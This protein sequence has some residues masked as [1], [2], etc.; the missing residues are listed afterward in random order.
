MKKIFCILSLCLLFSVACETENGV[1]TPTVSDSSITC[2]NTTIDGHDA[3]I[4]QPVD[5]RTKAPVVI[6]LTDDL[7]LATRNTQTPEVNVNFKVAEHCLIGGYKICVIKAQINDNLSFL[8]TAKGLFAGAS[9]FYLL[10]YRNGL[11]YTAAMQMPET[12]NAYG[13]VSGAID[14]ATYKT[15]SFTKPVSF[16][17]V[18]A[19]ENP[20]FQW[21]GV[22]NKSVSV[23]LSIGAIVAINECTHYTTSEFYPREGQGRVSCTNYLGGKDGYDVK[24]YS[25]ESSN[26]GWCDAEFEVYN[27]IWN[28]FKTH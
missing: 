3:V 25:V 27:Q 9:K 23:P 1:E 5:A 14:V 24:L 10:S 15:N 21:L 4:I 28:F 7:E 12:F 11:A 8:N 26:S 13:C 18:H 6:I 17:H 2:T 20:E 22:E 16:V 19:T